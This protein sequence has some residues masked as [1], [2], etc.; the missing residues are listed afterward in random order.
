MLE[1]A[2]LAPTNEAWIDAPP[3]P[4]AHF[5][6]GGVRIAMFDIDAWAEAG[7]APAGLDAERLPTAFDHFTARQRQFAAVLAAHDVPVT[8]DHCPAGKDARKTLSS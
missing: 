6:D 8:F 7:F 5:V 3:E 1:S 2:L 4:L